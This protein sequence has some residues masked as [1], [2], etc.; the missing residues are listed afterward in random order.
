MQTNS[1]KNNHSP[2]HPDSQQKF[3]DEVPNVLQHLL[4]LTKTS[5]PAI[6]LYLQLFGDKYLTERILDVDAALDLIN[7]QFHKIE[8][9]KKPSSTI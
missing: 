5:C 8:N 1:A 9:T 4:E 3:I 7:E 6:R 2:V